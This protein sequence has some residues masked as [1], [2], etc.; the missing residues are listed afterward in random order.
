MYQTGASFDSDI[1]RTINSIQAAGEQVLSNAH[2]NL[3]IPKL[4]QSMYCGAYYIGACV[5]GLLYHGM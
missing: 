2:L 1:H 5:L 3:F 4:V